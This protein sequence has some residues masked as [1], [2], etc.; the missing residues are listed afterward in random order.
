MDWWEARQRKSAWEDALKEA[1]FEV[2]ENHWEEG[3]W[4]SASGAASIEKLIQSYPEMDAV[5]AAN[6]Q[7]AL[8]IIQV[9]C[10]KNLKIPEDLGIVGF[11]NIAESSYFC[12]PLTTIQSEQDT[13]GRMA[14]EK[15]VKLIESGWND[16]EVFDHS[17]IMLTPTLIVRQSSVINEI[18]GERRR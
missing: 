7:M 17:P 12:P 1:G 11:D 10:Q 13:V 18:P 15:M 2:A 4:S 8:S 16:Q 14:V 9:A 5:F 3:N 6:D